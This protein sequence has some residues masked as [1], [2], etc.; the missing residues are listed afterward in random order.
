M[1]FQPPRSWNPP[2]DDYEVLLTSSLLGTGMFVWDDHADSNEGF[3]GQDFE[4]ACVFRLQTLMHIKT[5]LGINDKGDE[6]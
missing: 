6:V 2:T 1:P 4:R 5:A 3:L